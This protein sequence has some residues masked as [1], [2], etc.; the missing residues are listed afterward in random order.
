MLRRREGI[1]DWLSTY[2]YQFFPLPP[3]L[4]R[5]RELFPEEYLMEVAR[6]FY[7]DEM[8]RPSEDPIMLL[9]L[10]F[11]SF[12]DAVEGDTHILSTLNYRLDWRQFCGLS[13]FASVP[14]RTTL[15][16]FRRRVGPVIIDALFEQI[17]ETLRE[18]GLL[19]SQHRCFDGTPA[20]ARACINPYR[21]EIYEEPLAQMTA[22]L[23][24][25]PASTVDVTP[26]MNPSPVHL[27]KTNYPVDQQAVQR[28]RQEA[29]KPVS[30]RQSAGDPEARFQRSKHGR[31]SELGYEIF[32]TTDCHQLFIE[33]VD[34]SATSCQGQALFA[35]KLAQSEPGQEWSVD[36]EF[37]TGA[38]LEQAEDRK[39]ILNTPPR[40]LSPT[41]LFSK[42][43]FLYQSDLDTY[44]CPHGQ[45]LSYVSTNRKTGP[46]R[47]VRRKVPVR[48]VPCG[49]SVPRRRLS[50]R[51][52]V[53][54]TKPSLSANGS[55]PSP[56]RPS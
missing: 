31:P 26:E 38:L 21:D 30:E 18:R 7:D 5:I 10:L 23:E 43:T 13:L 29:M 27:T 3:T 52:P 17:V 20:T 44:L 36:A 19:D 25:T 33:E 22:K 42:T 55:M 16:T 53:P 15:V 37:S 14:A 2:V 51:S 46:E 48:T 9:K 41:G 8:G 47:I 49:N 24:Q 54:A 6:P 35:D 40:I 56:P 50:G 11:L 39:V 45:T 28:R 34:V 1:L 4:Q 32:F 12:Y